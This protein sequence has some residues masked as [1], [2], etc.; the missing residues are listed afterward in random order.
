MM[1]GASLTPHRPCAVCAASAGWTCSACFERCT[2]YAPARTCARFTTRAIVPSRKA[3]LTVRLRRVLTRRPSTQGCRPGRAGALARS[4]SADDLRAPRR[5]EGV[6][7][8]RVLLPAVAYRCGIAR[9]AD[10][11]SE[12]RPRRTGRRVRA[13]GTR[14]D[15]EDRERCDRQKRSYTSSRGNSPF[16]HFLR[17]VVGPWRRRYVRS[18]Y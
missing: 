2:E 7:E 14:R 12:A 8:G 15:P 3:A 11:G 17:R 10:G 4:Q 16:H 5:V 9:M 6:L 1:I 13:R 18:P